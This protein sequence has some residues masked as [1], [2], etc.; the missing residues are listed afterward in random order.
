M[1]KDSVKSSDALVGGGIPRFTFKRCPVCSLPFGS[2]PFCSG[3]FFPSHPP[4]YF[5]DTQSNFAANHDTQKD[6]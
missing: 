1:A 4:V 6:G 5:M 3:G 2:K